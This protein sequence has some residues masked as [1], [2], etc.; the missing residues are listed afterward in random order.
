MHQA[1]PTPTTQSP[2][3]KTVKLKS[4]VTKVP[5]KKQTAESSLPWP[6]WRL[7]REAPYNEFWSQPK[8]FLGYIMTFLKRDMIHDKAHAMRYFG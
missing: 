8:D 3:P 2:V 5:P 1:S 7:R 6:S 4:V